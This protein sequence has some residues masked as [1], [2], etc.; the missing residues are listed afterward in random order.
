MMTAAV[1][2]CVCVFVFVRDS[3]ADGVLLVVVV[4]LRRQ[5]RAARLLLLLTTAGA[6]LLGLVWPGFQRRVRCG[7]PRRI[8][9]VCVSVCVGEGVRALVYV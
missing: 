1:F 6:G 2:M 8:L 9:Y 5:R 3:A 7:A 4:M